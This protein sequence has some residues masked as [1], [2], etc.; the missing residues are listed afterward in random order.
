VHLAAVSN[1][2]IANK[3]D[4]YDECGE[5]KANKDIIESNDEYLDM[6]LDVSMSMTGLHV[7]TP[8]QT[9][10]R[11]QSCHPCYIGHMNFNIPKMARI[12]SMI[13]LLCDNAFKLAAIGYDLFFFQDCI[14]DDDD[15]DFV[16]TKN[17]LKI[18]F[19][20]LV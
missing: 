7:F 12:H 2:G 9:I 6:I 18:I 19:I 5:D 15:N 3:T 13:N 1:L 10:M 14:L 11:T 16:L 4:A 20:T 8:L 17:T